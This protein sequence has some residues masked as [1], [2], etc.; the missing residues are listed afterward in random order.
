MGDGTLEPSQWVQIPGALLLLLAFALLMTQTLSSRSRIYMG[1]NLCG[2]GL[3]AF[4]AWRT[5]Q[6]GFFLLEGTW[7]FIAAWAL[8]RATLSRNPA[9]RRSG[10]R[11]SG[12]DRT[13]SVPGRE[14]VGSPARTDS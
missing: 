10:G 14:A 4:E 2:G 12:R 11:P 1:L 8:L 6:Y 13:S 7:A 3:L 9:A 5:Y